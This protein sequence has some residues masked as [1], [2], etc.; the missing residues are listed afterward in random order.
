MLAAGWEGGRD[1]VRCSVQPGI[2]A[3]PLWCRTVAVIN[4]TDVHIVEA[5]IAGA[6]LAAEE[7]PSSV[8]EERRVTTS[9]HLL[10]CESKRG[11]G[12]GMNV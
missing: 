11:S 1:I 4:V 9:D 10:I 8:D 6:L 5:E 12:Y 2:V 7:S 3:E